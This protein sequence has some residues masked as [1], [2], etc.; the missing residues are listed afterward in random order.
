M[1][2]RKL[3][4]P[5][6][7]HC[8]SPLA[9]RLRG[10]LARWLPL[11]A[12]LVLAACGGD[13]SDSGDAAVA[14][15]SAG[16]TLAY[17]TN[18]YSQQVPAQPL[19]LVVEADSARAVTQRVT[20]AQGGILRATGADGAAFELTVPADA[21]AADIDVTMTPIGRFTRLPFNGSD[22][23]TAWGVQL[24]PSG[25]RFLKPARLRITPPTGV[26]VAVAQQLPFG[27]EADVVQLA[28]LDPASREVDLQV[29]HFSGYALGRF[30]EQVDGM[31]AALQN[32][33]D[34]L[35][36]TPERRMET[37]AAE[38]AA[39]KRREALTG[40]TD[41]YQI[42][43]DDFRNY[44]DGYLAGVV[45]PRIDASGGCAN[46]RVAFE[47]VLNVQNLLR[48]TNEAPL[49]W[50]PFQTGQTEA[51]MKQVAQACLTVEYARCT[52]DHVV[53]DMITA[54]QGIDAEA[55][56]IAVDPWSADWKLWRARAEEQLSQCHRYRLEI[57]ST[58]GTNASG[59]EGW[60]FSERMEGLVE[61]HL[62]GP[63]LE[64]SEPI[65]VKTFEIVGVGEVP[66]RSYS[67][68]YPDACSIAADVI[69]APT[70]FNVSRLAF[71]RSQDGGLGDLRL[72]YF[73]GINTSSHLFVDPCSDPPTQVRLPLFAWSNTFLV[74][75]GSDDRY[76][77]P[78]TA[79]FFLDQWIMD[80]Q[81]VQGGEKTMA[82]HVLESFLA[83]GTISYRTGMSLRLVHTPRLQ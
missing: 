15:D 11:G 71:A 61:L 45:R 12:I 82:T 1:R 43:A 5:F 32:L 68:G 36:S 63:V 14:P 58:S 26:S 65:G 2:T 31:N 24:E 81:P 67:I 51:L 49:S 38:R 20:A 4:R 47:T 53:T 27:W 77:D 50:E 30:A 13:G 70:L 16:A 10:R 44:F 74:S 21:L 57:D 46:S 66:S 56:R 59:S 62:S 48:A 54:V 39:A 72:E 6:D 33:R 37:V 23:A 76:F 41:P 3:P 52:S 22:A 83:D 34:R 25:T 78:K 35:G 28:L 79:G 60:Q 75:V 7:L 42:S 19:T 8:R 69:Q 18:P 29:L 73:P 9:D 80:A 55:R 64:F 40:Q 17:S